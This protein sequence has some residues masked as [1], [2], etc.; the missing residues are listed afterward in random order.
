MTTETS[1]FIHS[2]LCVGSYYLLSSSLQSEDSRQ[3]QEQLHL[4]TVQNRGE[5]VVGIYSMREESNF[6]IINYLI[7]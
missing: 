7:N 2:A 3:P 5:T 6:N 4:G 1:S